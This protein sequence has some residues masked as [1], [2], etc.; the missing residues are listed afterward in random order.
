MSNRIYTIGREFGS[1]GRE[2]GQKLA[3][4]LGIQCYDSRLI[5][6]AS[7]DGN[8]DIELLKP[9]EEKRASSLLYSMYY[10]YAADVNGYGVP[11][12][13]KLHSLQSDVI[14][15]LAERES[16]III[17]RCADYELAEFDNVCSAFIFADLDARIDRIMKRYKVDEKTAKNMIK[18]YD[19]QRKNYYNFYTGL[20]W[21]GRDTYDICMNSSTLGI[22]TCVNI[23]KAYGE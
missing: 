1:G 11:M 7:K 4:E 17:G 20:E 21:G 2:I 22:D 15:K 9:V 13:D 14:R 23:L 19:K 16:C 10:E 12:N 6:M 8:I 18:K 3:N 5:E